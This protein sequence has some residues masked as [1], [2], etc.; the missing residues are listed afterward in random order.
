[1]NYR[2]RA[3]QANRVDPPVEGENILNSYAAHVRR[4]GDSRTPAAE[5]ALHLSWMFHQV[6][7]IHQPLHAVARFSAALPD[8]DRGGNSVIFPNPT[9]RTDRGNNLHAYWDDLLGTDEEPDAVEALAAGIMAEHPRTNLGD[10]LVRS[11]I[12]QWAEESVAISLK[13]VYRN[14]DPGLT[15]FTDRPVGYDADARKVARRQAAL[16]GYRL[17]DALKRIVDS[18]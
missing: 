2:I 6:G 8:G 12:N 4:A 16:A 3:D 14:L 9:A 11:R 1:V 15:R 10:E 18:K 5:R 13:T 7:D 17:A